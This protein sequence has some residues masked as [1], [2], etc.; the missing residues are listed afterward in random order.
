MNKRWVIRDGSYNWLT[1]IVLPLAVWLM[2]FITS[3]KCQQLCPSGS[4]SSEYLC[5]FCNWQLQHQY[6]A[7]TG[8]SVQSKCTRLS[9]HCSFAETP[10]WA[11]E[12]HFNL[13]MKAPLNQKREKCLCLW[14]KIF[15]VT[16]EVIWAKPAIQMVI[17]VCQQWLTTMVATDKFRLLC[18]CF[19]RFW[20]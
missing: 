9:A 6:A 18:A 7:L 14:H 15:C 10:W 3:K 2:N 8:P 13:I 11:S 4:S 20:Y 5:G 1:R 19:W 16:T 17:Q 12:W